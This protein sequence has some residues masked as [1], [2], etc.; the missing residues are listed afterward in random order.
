MAKEKK[1]EKSKEKIIP[2]VQSNPKVDEI[3]ATYPASLKASPRGNFEDQ[4]RNHLLKH[5]VK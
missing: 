2:R 4:L 1:K 5:K 3:V